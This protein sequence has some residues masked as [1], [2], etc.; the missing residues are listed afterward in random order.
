MSLEFRRSSTAAAQSIGMALNSRGGVLRSCGRAFVHFSK[1]YRRSR[2]SERQ[3]G[4]R[5]PE[6][7]A[8]RDQLG[9]HMAFV[10]G[11]ELDG[12]R[13]EALDQARGEVRVSMPS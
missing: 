9:A 12:A 11:K 1:I 7:A 13:Q 4:H 5:W 10:K 2:G 8:E 6:K 3:L